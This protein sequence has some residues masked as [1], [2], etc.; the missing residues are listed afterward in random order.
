MVSP[1]TVALVASPA[2]LATVLTTEPFELTTISLLVNGNAVA[3]GGVQLTVA[4][5]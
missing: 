5:P 3:G 1:V 4:W 2:R